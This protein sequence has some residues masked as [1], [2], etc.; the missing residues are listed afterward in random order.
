M[1]GGCE[2][3]DTIENNISEDHREMIQSTPPRND[4]DTMATRGW[5]AQIVRAPWPRETG[6]DSLPFLFVSGIAEPRSPG[7]AL[8]LELDDPDPAQLATISVRFI[9][10][11][12]ENQS[13]ESSPS[14]RVAQSFAISGRRYQTVIVK[15]N[16]AQI[17]AIALLGLE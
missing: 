16:E 8:S 9:A 1:L 4:C 6:L 17:A 7:Y 3:L 10:T 15:C 14:I 12:P 13:S 5:D 2:D 11:G